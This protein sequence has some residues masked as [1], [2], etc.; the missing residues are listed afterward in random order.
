MTAS[1]PW[2]EI[3]EWMVKSRKLLIKKLARNDSSWADNPNNHQYGPYIPQ[4]IRA[5]D[6][7]PKL[8]NKNPSKPHIYQ[9]GI[10][11]FWPSTGEVKQSNLRHFSNKG[12][13]MHFTGVPKGEFAGLTPASFLVGGLLRKPIGDTHHWFITIDSLSEEAALIETAF[14]LPADFHFGL[15][16]P[17]D[18]FSAAY[19]ETEQLIQEI[20]AAVKSGTLGA[21]L[22]AASQIPPS[23]VLADKAQQI[24]LQQ[25]SLSA[26]NPYELSSPGDAVMEISR[27]IEYTL[28][29]SAEQRHRAAEVIQIITKGG[30]DI[31]ASVVRGYPELN[32]TFLSASQVR[33]SRA[34]R[35]FEHHIARLLRDGQ[36]IF[37]E[38]A[39]TGGRRPDFVLP[40]VKT[41]K[42]KVR[43]YDKALILSLK[44]TLRE[45]WKQV[46]MEKFN[47][48][49]FL[50]TVDDRVSADAIEDMR[51]LGVHLLVPESLKES[52]ETCYS[53]KANVITF[54]DFFDEEILAKRPSF[55]TK[56]A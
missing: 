44:T 21:F 52:K 1:A 15:F 43:T 38:Q 6:F 37:Q 28:Y 10:E 2:N 22:K 8:L 27:D 17:E 56:N 7:F 3:Y 40:N 29:K 5:S 11:T 51:S 16:D 54:R 48:A 30:T 55:R 19:D 24:F 31:I 42:A 26:L 33:K 18:I 25:H 35:S 49:L 14:D 4:E 45:R 23:S 9:A 41:L 13:E 32:A 50:A 34:G 36:I 47:C 46:P 20:S 53:N 39:I 12:S